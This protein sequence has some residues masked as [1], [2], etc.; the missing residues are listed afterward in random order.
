M[1]MFILMKHITP[2][3]NVFRQNLNGRFQMKPS[4]F[5]RIFNKKLYILLVEEQ[6]MEFPFAKTLT[7]SRK[8]NKNDIS[9]TTTRS[10]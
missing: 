6:R 10:S 4:E 9:K 1:I 2:V 8:E 3:L 5:L 7:N